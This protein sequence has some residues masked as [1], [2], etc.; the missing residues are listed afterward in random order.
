MMVEYGSSFLFEVVNGIDS[1]LN[2]L[3]VSYV[4]KARKKMCTRQNT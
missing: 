3:S 1:I 2:Q 4:N